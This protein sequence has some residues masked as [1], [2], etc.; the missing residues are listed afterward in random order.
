MICP[1]CLRNFT[2]EHK[3]QV[4]CSRKC[5]KAAYY[6]RECARDEPPNANALRYF[7]CEECGRGVNIYTKAD[8]RY[9]FC[10]GKCY[11]KAK[12]RRKAER[13]KR[14]RGNLGISGGM[15]LGNLIRRERRSLD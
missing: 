1:Q 12:D 9:R 11:M 10:S 14:L 2:P 15:C 13:R 4:Y 8:P 6:N 7:H 3:N 5:C